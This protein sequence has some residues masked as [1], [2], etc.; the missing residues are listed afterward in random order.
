[1]TIINIAEKSRKERQVYSERTKKNIKEAKLSKKVSFEV[2]NIVIK[3]FNKNFV[4]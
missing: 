3:I 4:T 1:M 2:Q